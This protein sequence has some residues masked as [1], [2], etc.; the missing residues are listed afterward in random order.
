MV[1]PND[2]HEPEEPT[3]VTE[4]QKDAEARTVIKEMTIQFKTFRSYQ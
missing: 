1:L 3:E 4:P 2:Y